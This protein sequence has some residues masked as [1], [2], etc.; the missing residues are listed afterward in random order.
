MNKIKKADTVLEDKPKLTEVFNKKA[1]VNKLIQHLHKVANELGA[2]NARWNIV[3]L[4]KKF[5]EAIDRK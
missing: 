2:T 4:K 5:F 3:E 1:E